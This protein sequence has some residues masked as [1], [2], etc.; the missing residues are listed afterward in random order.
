MNRIGQRSAAYLDVGQGSGVTDGGR[1]FACRP[2]ARLA[3][4]LAA[5]PEGVRRLYLCGEL[6]QL[7]GSVV[8]ADEHD[9]VPERAR[10]RGDHVAGDHV[11]GDD[12]DDVLGDDADADADDGDDPA[13][14][15]GTPNG[16]LRW[17]LD[18]PDTVC[19]GWQK[20]PTRGHHLVTSHAASCVLRFRHA[21][22]G[23]RLDVCSMRGWFGDTLA[24]S[25]TPAD[26]RDAFAWLTCRIA[27]AFA[28][29][30]L[31]GSTSQTGLHTWRHAAEQ[32]GA[33]GRP[34]IERY[35]MLP[36]DLRALLHHTS[37]QGR[38]ELFRPP[39]ALTARGDPWALRV[40]SLSYYDGRLMYVASMAGLGVGPVMHDERADFAPYHP[41]WYQVRFTVPRDWRH[42]GIL[43]VQVAGTQRGWAWPSAPGHAGETWA[44]DR[45]G[46]AG[47][48]A[49]S[50]PV[51][52]LRRGVSHG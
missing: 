47:L 13:P 51:P 49:V 20:E 35:P 9:G 44:S 17:G 38:A 52:C 21:A 39:A 34:L 6:P 12:D 48:L 10:H 32:P 26:A 30:A 45:E 42:P 36:E 15:G 46:G 18:T 23:R 5:V 16:Y 25:C 31:L 41:A 11:A 19:P 24:A 27:H 33:D 1:R 8:A 50:T 22:D 28:G 3:E 4:V 7:H 43:P 14:A 40:S 2:G 29:A 37:G